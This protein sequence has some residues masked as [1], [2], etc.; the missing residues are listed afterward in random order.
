[1]VSP[2]PKKGPQFREKSPF[3]KV[4]S[5]TKP[6]NQKEVAAPGL[7]ALAACAAGCGWRGA[8]EGNMHMIGFPKVQGY[9][10][11]VLMIR[12]SYTIWGFIFGSLMFVN[13]Q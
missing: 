8:H 5:F 1:M 13:P 3:L 11:G 12:E 6:C 7:A 2:P 9:L 10:L 4:V